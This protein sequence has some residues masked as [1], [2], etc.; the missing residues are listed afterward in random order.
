MSSEDLERASK[1][2]RLTDPLHPLLS[3]ITAPVVPNSITASTTTTNLDPSLSSTTF[4]PTTFN[5]QQYHWPAEPSSAGTSGGLPLITALD[6]QTV[7]QALQAQQGVVGAPPA[8]LD[9]VRYTTEAIRSAVASGSMVGVAA[10]G[11]GVQAPIFRNQ[12]TLNGASVGGNITPK[13]ST[14]PTPTPTVAR[15]RAEEIPTSESLNRPTNTASP[16]APTP[17]SR[18]PELKVHHKLAERARRKEVKDLFDELRELL[19]TERG[20]K[21]SKWEIL[22]RGEFGNLIQSFIQSASHPMKKGEGRCTSADK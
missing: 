16:S 13:Q 12:E 17:F 4:D 19:P 6:D 14:M 3:T 15:I 8:S 10:G 20:T 5:H 21:S 11:N 2:I 7:V 22:K 1:R 9:D 18:T